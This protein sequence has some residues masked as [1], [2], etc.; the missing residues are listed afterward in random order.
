MSLTS[1]QTAPPRNHLQVEEDR[2]FPQCCKREFEKTACR[3][4]PFAKNPSFF[5][6]V[7]DEVL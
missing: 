3:G 6:D 7:G 1:Y 2:L 5:G 4:N